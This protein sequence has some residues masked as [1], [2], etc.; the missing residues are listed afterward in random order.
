MFCPS[1]TRPKTTLP[2]WAWPQVDSPSPCPLSRHHWRPYTGW[3][4]AAPAIPR[5]F[6]TVTGIRGHAQRFQIHQAGKASVPSLEGWSL[7]DLAPV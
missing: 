2:T 7:E 5:D 4:A 1:G 6:P 3:P